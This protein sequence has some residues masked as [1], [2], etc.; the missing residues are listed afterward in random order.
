MFCYSVYGLCLIIWSGIWSENQDILSV[1][2][3][4]MVE[5][6]CNC[7]KKSL[8]T[9]EFGNSRCQ[10]F[11]FLGIIFSCKS[12]NLTTFPQFRSLLSQGKTILTFVTFLI[13]LWFIGGTSKPRALLR[14][15]EDTKYKQL[16]IK[17]YLPDRSL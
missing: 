1:R 13:D 17:H 5:K 3:Q 12:C 9:L 16:S 8:D 6:P 15:G 10:G 7:L 4:I 2:T 14:L 11:Q